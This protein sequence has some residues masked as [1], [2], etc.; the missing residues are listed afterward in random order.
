MVGLVVA[1]TVGLAGVAAAQDNAIKLPIYN[2]PIYMGMSLGF[3]LSGEYTGNIRGANVRGAIGRIDLP[4]SDSGSDS[5]I[6]GPSVGE[7]ILFGW[8]LNPL[9]SLEAYVEDRQ[10][11]FT[12]V[13]TDGET[14]KFS[15]DLNASIKANRILIMGLARLEVGD[16]KPIRPYLRGG[17]GYARVTDSSAPLPIVPWETTWRAFLIEGGGV[18]KLG[19][20]NLGE[21]NIDLGYRYVGMTN[22]SNTVRKTIAGTTLE[23]SGKNQSIEEHSFAMTV[24]A[25]GSYLEGIL[26]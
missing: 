2:L 14:L 4:S 12:T 21:I 8:K 26:Y 7:S 17:I 25:S 11:A 18:A 22:S 1:S 10:I 24:F 6:L 16:F 20:I 15:D 23:I 13:T 5:A 9:I 3:G 19:D